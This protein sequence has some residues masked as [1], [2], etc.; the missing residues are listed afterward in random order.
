[1]VP[2]K[3]SLFEQE[4]YSVQQTA[5]NSLSDLLCSTR[6]QAEPLIIV[7]C[8]AELLNGVCLFLGVTQRRLYRDSLPTILKRHHHR[9]KQSL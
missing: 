2:G 9:L 3:P 1:M 4:I 8:I 6:W 7:F 5:V